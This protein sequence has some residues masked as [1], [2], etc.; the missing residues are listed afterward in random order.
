[1]PPS[2]GDTLATFSLAAVRI[3]LYPLHFALRILGRLALLAMTVVPVAIPFLAVYGLVVLW[4]ENDI[5]TK[6]ASWVQEDHA[7]VTVLAYF[8]TLGLFAS[9]LK[10]LIK[11]FWAAVR[12]TLEPIWDVFRGEW[13][14]SAEVGES[15]A[16]T[17][18]DNIGKIPD[19][20]ALTASRA[21][22]V[23]LAVVVGTIAVAVTAPLV[24]R[25]PEVVDRYVWVV[26]ADAEAGAEQPD[27]ADPPVEAETPPPSPPPQPPTLQAHLRNGTVFSLVHQEN[28]QPKNGDGICLEEPHQA[29]LREFRDAV[30]KCVSGQADEAA[31]APRFEVRAF[32][33]IAP[34]KANGIPSTVSNC[35]IANRR[36]DAVGAFLANEDKYKKKWQCPQVGEDFQ[37]TSDLCAADPDNPGDYDGLHQGVNF[38]VYVHRWK[39]PDKMQQN[40]PAD[41]G[42]LPEDRRYAAEWF[43]R[44]VHITAPRGFCRPNESEQSESS[45]ATPPE[46]SSNA[47]E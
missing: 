37:K 45:A 7:L 43:N 34:V 38:K 35:E 20:M 23:T 19:N 28:A 39:T 10:T 24:L 14:P 3:V 36:A 32:A 47:P 8:I 2:I 44:S 30:A 22:L 4:Q 11:T 5:G 29:W 17:W 18:R 13:V 42:A 46:E 33:S 26:T 40:K 6:I 1:M 27:G 41:D 12:D 15:L 21:A 31:S 9:F 16:V 25:D